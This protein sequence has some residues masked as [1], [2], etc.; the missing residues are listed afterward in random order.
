[1]AIPITVYVEN[2]S[3]KSMTLKAALK[4]DI[5]FHAEGHH[6]AT[7]DKIVRAIGNQ[8]QPNCQQNEVLSLLIPVTAPILHNICPIINIEYKIVVTLDIPGSFDLHCELPVIL[9]N[10]Q[11][12]FDMS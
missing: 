8:I 11:L 3:K 2:K 9:T 1:M 4:Q 5:K 7:T 12:P 6:K 10:L